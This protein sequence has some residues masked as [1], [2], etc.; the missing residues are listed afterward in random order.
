MKIVIL[1][2]LGMPG[3]AGIGL[4]LFCLPFYFGNIAPLR[5]ELTSLEN[6]KAQLAATAA[7]LADAAHGADSARGAGAGKGLPHLTAAPELLMQLNSLAEKHGLV[8]ERTS[9]QFK[10][11]DGSPRL[12]ISMPLKASYPSLRAYLRDA[13]ALTTSASLDELTLQRSQASDPAVDAQVRLS[14]G[15]AATP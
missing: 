1:E 9:Y 4:L 7:A 11:K 8:V 15:F 6:E 2:K 14:Y 5:N 10:G 13:L 12:E 3:V